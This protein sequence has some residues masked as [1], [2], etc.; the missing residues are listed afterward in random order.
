MDIAAK[1]LFNSE[2]IEKLKKEVTALKSQVKVR[3]GGGVNN[4]LL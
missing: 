4:G 2:E 1:K 3:E